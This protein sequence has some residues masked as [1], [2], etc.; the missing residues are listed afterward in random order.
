MKGSDTE[1]EQGVWEGV[2]CLP[3]GRKITGIKSL[4][5]AHRWQL[6]KGKKYEQFTHAVASLVCLHL[7]E[8]VSQTGCRES[9]VF[10]CGGEA[11]GDRAC[12]LGVSTG[13]WEE[14]GKK[15]EKKENSPSKKNTW[16]INKK[17][18]INNGKSTVD[19]LHFNLFILWKYK[20]PREERTGKAYGQARTFWWAPS[21][22]GR[23]ARIIYTR[24]QTP[25]LT[26]NLSSDDE[27]LYWLQCRFH[28][29]L[30]LPLHSHTHT[31]N[32]AFHTCSQKWLR[33]MRREQRTENSP[34]RTV[35]MERK[36]Y[37]RGN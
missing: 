4:S 17:R 3:Q 31:Q 36:G 8:S 5:S 15:G 20:G 12:T 11:W 21:W 32:S 29:P 37:D 35:L 14:K 16:K 10:T 7:R 30:T 28:Q 33:L 24:I 34:S 19:S 18:H 23:D 13:E 9:S 27:A 2:Y 25:A 6:I 1:A 26:E 22:R